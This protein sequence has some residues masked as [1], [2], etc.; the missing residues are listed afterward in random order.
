[1]VL[2]SLSGELLHVSWLCVAKWGKMVEIGKR[3]LLGKSHL[4]LH[5][6]L[7]NR[8]YHCVALDGVLIDRPHVLQ[9]YVALV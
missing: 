4:S 1:M 2:N 3:D 6:F 7:H 5:P 9:E 8:S